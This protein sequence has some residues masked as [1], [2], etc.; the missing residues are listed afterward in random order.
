MKNM[1]PEEILNK[2]GKR[3]MDNTRKL[4][5][6]LK[7]HADAVIELN[8]TDQIMK[9][10]QSAGNHG[11]IQYLESVQRQ[12]LASL[13]DTVQNIRVRVKGRLLRSMIDN[14]TLYEIKDY[15]ERAGSV[16][17]RLVF[18][19]NGIL[20]AQTNTNG[21]VIKNISGRWLEKHFFILPQDEEYEMR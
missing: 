9:E 13:R 6:L 19:P 10:A 11:M 1:L 4:C 12:K 18:D 8:D 17:L 21:N 15:D 16:L 3:V 7:M 2:T 5:D 14:I 20:I